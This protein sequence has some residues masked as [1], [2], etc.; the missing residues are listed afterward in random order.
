MQEK[1]PIDLLTHK[2][3]DV[4]VKYLYASNLSNGFYK[5]MY[6]EHIKVWNNFREGEKTRF[7]DFDSTFKSIIEG[8]VNEPVP[9]NPDGHIANGAHRLAAAL[10]RKRPIYVRD[11]NSDEN[12]DIRS[13]Y[14]YF[15]G[16][17]LSKTILQRAAL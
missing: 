6:K 17:N 16:S 1:N 15:N 11:T 10:Y 5:W 9:V 7:E 2:R 12:Y 13:D 3:L 4:V 8:P 14:E